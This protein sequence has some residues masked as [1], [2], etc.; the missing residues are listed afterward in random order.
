[1]AFSSGLLHLHRPVLA[2][3]QKLIF[4]SSNQKKKR[5]YTER[6]KENEQGS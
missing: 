4:L 1:M 6:K 2:D 5:T 3:N